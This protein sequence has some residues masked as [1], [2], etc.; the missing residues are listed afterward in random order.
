MTPM[1]TKGTGVTEEAQARVTRFARQTIDV[2]LPVLVGMMAEQGQDLPDQ[3]QRASQLVRLLSTARIEDRLI[4][5]GRPVPFQLLDEDVG[6]RL[7]LN[8]EM[9]ARVDDTALASAMAGPLAELLSMSQVA[10]GLVLQLSDENQVRGLASQ[11]GAGQGRVVSLTEI[12]ALVDWRLDAFG[13]RVKALVDGLGG[14]F[15]V[16]HRGREEF[17]D[18]IAGHRTGWPQWS[19]VEDHEFIDQWTARARGELGHTQWSDFGPELVEMVW[20]SLVISPRSALRQAAQSLRSLSVTA[21]RGELLAVMAD[22][23]GG[24]DDPVRGELAAWPGF[25]E[26]QDAWLGLWREEDDALGARRRARE[27]PQIS[28]F[29]PPGTSMGIS[30][31]ESL[32]WSQPLLCWTQRERA[33]LR[34]L[35]SG[36]E[37]SLARTRSQI[38]SGR[39]GLKATRPG[40][41]LVP[42]PRQGWLIQVPRQ[43]PPISEYLPPAVDRAFASTL[44]TY[45]AAFADLDQATQNRALNLCRGAYSGY[46]ESTGSVWQRRLATAPSDSPAETFHSL[47]TAVATALEWPIFIDV[48]D[49][50]PDAPFL[51]MMPSFTILA[52]WTPD[53][54]FAPVWLPVETIGEALGQAPVRL[55]NVGIDKQ[56]VCRWLGD[57]QVELSELRAL[58]TD[59]LMRSVHEGTLMMTLHTL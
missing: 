28:L 30:E 57:H 10:V 47:I 9:L 4:L 53:A 54:D 58:S 25:A 43:I 52:V 18:A 15:K 17:I 32:P 26:L 36:M 38:R 40:A 41:P 45:E 1:I 34:D 14:R 42:E 2:H 21:G 35:L 22:A 39:L 23:L 51:A 11:L 49:G 3:S 33:A 8:G 46:L 55:R 29:D 5:N 19:D 13:R 27:T 24:E 16:P 6:K 48:F 59:G 37:Q 44:A 50:D 20:E 56:G 31:P 12:E 7:V